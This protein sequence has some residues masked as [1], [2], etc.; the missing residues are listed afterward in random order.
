[1]ATFTVNKQLGQEGADAPD[2][3]LQDTT[4]RHSSLVTLVLFT[5][6]AA[7]C[8]THGCCRLL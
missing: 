4:T 7:V 1:L 5:E 2:V 3:V 6:I 8:A